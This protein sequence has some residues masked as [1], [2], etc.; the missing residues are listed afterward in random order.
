MTDGDG[1]GRRVSP[2]PEYMRPRV[3]ERALARC[4]RRAGRV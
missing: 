1:G 4:Q 2:S 3:R